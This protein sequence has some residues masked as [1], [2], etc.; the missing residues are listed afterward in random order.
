MKRVNM[1]IASFLL[2]FVMFLS[3][4]AKVQAEEPE[5]YFPVKNASASV[6]SIMHISA[7][8]VG[9][10]MILGEDENGTLSITL[11]SYDSSSNARASEQKDVAVFIFQHTNILGIKSDAYKVTLTCD[12]TKDGTNSK[13]NVL[14]GVYEI[15]KSGY[16]CEWTDS[17]YTEG[18]CWL[19]LRATY[20][21]G[22]M[23]TRFTALLFP[24]EEPILSLDCLNFT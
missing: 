8:N 7:D 10:T 24:V 5:T 9:N 11:V 6:Q 21:S 19:D 1:C 3:N 13:I 17:F 4:E 22:Y 23:D 18:H 14:H 12:W 15:I 20:G 16:S 2:I